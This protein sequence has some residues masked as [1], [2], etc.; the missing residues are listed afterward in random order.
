MTLNDDEEHQR[1]T[2]CWMKKTNTLEYQSLELCKNMIDGCEARLNGYELALAREELFYSW[3]GEDQDREGLLRA[4][5]TLQVL[6][7]W[8][9]PYRTQRPRTLEEAL[10]NSGLDAEMVRAEVKVCEEYHHK[11]CE[12]KEKR[13]LLGEKNFQLRY[14]VL[15]QKSRKGIILT[16]QERT[17]LDN[18]YEILAA[19]H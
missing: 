19:D 12:L 8:E 7:G 4:T 2:A 13:L 6:L 15:A 14:D 16:E 9:P 17:A 5:I 3:P 11:A 10:E 18:I 1:R